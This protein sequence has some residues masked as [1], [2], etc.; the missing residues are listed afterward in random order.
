MESI[1][2][3]LVRE[4]ILAFLEEQYRN[5][6]E[7]EKKKL[8]KA[9]KNQD[10]QKIAE[11]QETLWKIR[12][13]YQLDTWMKHAAIRMA[14]GL[15]FGTHISKGVHPDSKGDNVV[16][17]SVLPIPDGLVASQH[18]STQELDANGNAAYLPLAAFFDWVVDEKQD[19][20]LRHLIVDNHPAL[21]GVFASDPELSDSYQRAFQHCLLAETDQPKTSEKNKQIFWPRKVTGE[22]NLSYTCLIPLYPSALTHEV[23]GKINAI[24]FSEETKRA[25]ENRYK[26][27]GEQRSYQSFF[28]LA[29]IQ[30]GG[31][32]SQNVGRLVNKRKGRDY[33]LPSVPPSFTKSQGFHIGPNQKSFFHK[34]LKYYCKKELTA[35][36]E[37]IKID[38]NNV[39]IRNA[40]KAVLDTLLD[41][42]FLLAT[43]IQVNNPSGWSKK[44]PGLSYDERLWLD[45]GRAQLEG[46]EAF[47]EDR[48]TRDWRR[49]IEIRFANWVNLLLK[50]EFKQI[51]HDFG[52]AEQHEWRREL[53]DMMKQSQRQGLGVFL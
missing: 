8:D 24:R 11:I 19:T 16:F 30:L 17:Q 41:T 22:K 52:E 40:R 50:K 38:H 3:H 47:A 10:G 4:R 20:R 51:Q 12:E 49:E 37:I 53:K 32:N 5:K 34:G 35:L 6:A 31:G 42:I 28:N 25:W 45:P 7:P 1:T 9:E 18:I 48:E 26:G 15:K 29:A 21:K 46:E 27:R 39:Y 43:S 2:T 14:C 33:L 23:H 13:K 36:F 44:L